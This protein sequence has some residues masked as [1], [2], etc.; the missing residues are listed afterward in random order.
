VKAFALDRARV[1]AVGTVGRY[2]LALK[3]WARSLKAFPPVEGFSR[4]MLRD[5][6]AW[7]RLPE[8][9][10]HG[11]QRSIDSTRKIVEVLQLFWQW[12]FDEEV[13]GCPPVRALEMKRERKAR[14]KAPTWAQMDACIAAC[15]TEWHRRATMLLRFTGLRASQV[16]ALRWEDIDFAVL[17]L[18][19]R[20]GKSDREKEGRIIPM[21]AHLAA[22]LATWGTREGFIIP[23]PRK[24]GARERQLRGRDIGRAW[25]RAGVSDVIWKRRPDHAF[26]KG[27]VSGLRALGADADAVDVLV[28][29]STGLRGVYTD[30]DAL[31]LRA[32]VDLIPPLTKAAATNVIDLKRGTA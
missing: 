11:R 27:L 9:G 13:P 4:D 26:R 1:L 19:V 5:F 28:G 29:H 22:E 15:T 14:T 20:T 17:T 10:L 2:A 24:G 32:I 3:L 8:N 25:K 21:S 23:S 18:H 31:N 30:D 12:C 7:L 6:W 16:M